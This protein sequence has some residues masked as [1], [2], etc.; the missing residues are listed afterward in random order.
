[1]ADIFFTYYPSAGG[2]FDEDAITDL[3]HCCL[4]RYSTSSVLKKLLCVSEVHI[5][6]DGR[7][8][9]IAVEQ[10]LRTMWLTSL[11]FPRPERELRR[12]NAIVAAVGNNPPQVSRGGLLRWDI[13]IP[14]GQRG[15][16]LSQCCYSVCTAYSG[17][18]P[19][20]CQRA[21]SRALSAL[22]PSCIM[23]SALTVQPAALSHFDGTQCGLL[24]DRSG[25]TRRR[26]LFN[27]ALECEVAILTEFLPF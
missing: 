9:N 15:R 19:S 18:T 25:Q 23:Q 14:P 12:C 3:F 11:S 27:L 7:T 1:M 24:S 5:V 26:P 20:G 10:T 13:T 2:A 22:R 17:R 16:G 6:S 21:A 8:W 4:S